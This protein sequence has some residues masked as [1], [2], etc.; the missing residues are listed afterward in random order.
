VIKAT[1]GKNLDVWI[2]RLFPFLFWR[3]LD[4]NALTVTGALVSSGA[5]AALAAGRPVAGGLLM[6]A[7]GFF[8][9]VDGVVARHHG[10]STRFG[11][12]LDSTLDRWVDAVLMVGISVHYAREG[13]PQ[14]V[15]L[16]GLALAAMVLVSYS[17]ARAELVLPTF[18]VGLLER[19]ERVVILAA[20]AIFDLLVVALWIIAVGSAI[21]AAQR[22]AL[23]YREMQRLDAA[24]GKLERP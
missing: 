7:G 11:A 24:D 20:G 3:K 16:A 8:D 17:K 21:T 6:L 13:A 10:I 9:L 2:R 18:E 12:F 19:A 15:A 4:P 23:A 1:V 14:H 22:I 5:A